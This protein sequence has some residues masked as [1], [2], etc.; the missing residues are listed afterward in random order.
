MVS[1]DSSLELFGHFANRSGI[2]LH[3]GYLRSQWFRKPTPPAVGTEVG[4]E[5]A[6]SRLG[7]IDETDRNTV[8]HPDVGVRMQL[9]GPRFRKVLDQDFSD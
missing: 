1:A 6:A 8:E 4:V 2:S 3:P 7:V 5:T 9:T